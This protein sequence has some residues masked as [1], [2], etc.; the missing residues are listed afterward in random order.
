MKKEIQKEKNNSKKKNSNI[1]KDKINKSKE[2][3]TKKQN[4]SVTEVVVLIILTCVIS[5]F[6]GF[7]INRQTNTEI[8]N[9]K[10]VDKELQKFISAYNDVVENYYEDV[11]KKQLIED[12]ISGLFSSL[13]D[14]SN[15]L[16][17]NTADS[18]SKRLDGEY[19]GIGIEVITN[20]DGNIVILSV[21]E[22]TPA[23]KAGLKSGDIIKKINNKSM[24]N[25][26]SSDLVEII[27]NT[28]SDRI[29]LKILRGKEEKTIVVDKENVILNTVSSDIY[30]DSIGYI[31][32]DLFANNTSNL[33]KNALDKLESQKINGLIIDVRDN[34]GGHLTTVID[35][36]SDLISKDHV[37]Y[38]VQIKDK[39]TKYYSKGNADKKYPIVI[40]TN[41]NSA[42]ASEVLASALSE[43]LGS[44]LVGVKTYGK[45]T[46]QELQDLKSGD[47]YKIT[48]KKWLTSKGTWINEKGIK[49]DI[50]IKN[51]DEYY[52]NPTFDNDEQLKKALEQF[53]D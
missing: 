34:S 6:C 25:K 30:N 4:F 23:E 24:D 8:K 14:Y 15:Y 2:I 7:F 37:I 17:P 11:D 35:I 38:Q 46:I 52:E 51:S 40:L 45:G 44:K 16:N 19:K 21:I 1:S 22:G 29:T 5:F 32:I 41:E 10:I 33:F 28:M 49:P 12:A 48:T 42:S 31:K 3:K 43:Q 53:K 9:S 47:S 39:K 20:D 13:D 18:F 27:K 36:L 50:E 26:E